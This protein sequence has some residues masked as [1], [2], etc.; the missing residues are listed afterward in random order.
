ML[1]GPGISPNAARTKHFELLS[2]VTQSLI[3]RM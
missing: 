2:A 1:K 3:S